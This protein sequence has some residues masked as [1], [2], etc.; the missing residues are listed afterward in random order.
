V[1]PLSTAILLG[2]VSCAV[3][4][5]IY[6][7]IWFHDRSR[8][9]YLFF[10]FSCLS[11][12]AFAANEIAMMRASSVDEL[13]A[14]RHVGHVIAL[15]MLTS[16]ALFVRSYLD[17]GRLWL[18]VSV[19]GSR[20][21]IVVI[22]AFSPFTMN[23]KVISSIHTVQFLGEQ[24]AVAD[25]TLS[26]L[27]FIP[28]VNLLLFLA[29]C[30]DAAVRVWKRGERRLAVTVGG[31]IVLFCSAALMSS[32]L[33]M[34]GIIKAPVIV[35]P[36]FIGVILAM[37]FEITQKILRSDALSTQLLA[38]TTEAAERL[39]ALTVAA[40]AGN[41]GVW[42]RHIDSGDVWASEKFREIFAFT[43]DEKLTLD[44]IYS[45]IVEDDRPGIKQTFEKAILAGTY[46]GQYRIELPDGRVRC[47]DSHGKSGTS[48]DGARVVYGA[49]AD[50]TQ[51][52][53][54][55]LSINTLGGRLINA[56]EAERSRIARELHDHLS[57]SL[58]LLAIQLEVLGGEVPE[59]P[60]FDDRIRAL[61]AQ[62]QTLSMDIHRLSHELHPAK[63]EQLGL[64]PAIRG[65]C[66]ELG[67][68]RGLKI[69]FQH[70]ELPATLSNDLALCI[71]RI[72]QESLQNVVK[73][74]GARE[75]IVEIRSNADCI[76]LKVTDN[77]KGFDTTR[78]HGDS[79]GLVSMNERVLAVTGSFSVDSTV[80]KGTTVRAE[81][82]LASRYSVQA[83][84]A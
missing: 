63:L 10:T 57:Q 8:R 82:P 61:S 81:I 32:I 55:E 6:F 52:K 1:Y 15:A 16:I 47:I 2:L 30:G 64:A 19:I 26:P 67:D 31:G 33:V 48:P 70:D 22:D 56:Q 37:S 72:V 12:A 84:G 59:H 51:R 4:G 42:I 71:Y 3:F 79:L 58:A 65:Y 83:P 62:V 13:I 76:S 5:A 45:R 39:Q 34:G 69:D 29:Y 68:V 49:S 38:K 36:F 50:V 17:P 77:G 23:F 74:S 27:T 73:H 21:A 46:A 11:V 7:R 43:A 44:D 35:S 41:V 20:A 54:A 75:A 60:E 9:E 25:A 53:L 24:I 80:G 18:L 28:Y 14:R 78:S 66:R 40:D